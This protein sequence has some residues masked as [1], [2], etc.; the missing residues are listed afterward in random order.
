MS[1]TEPK[2][3]PVS[4]LTFYL[5]HLFESNPILNGVQ[6][7][8]EVSNLTYHRSGHVY[9]SLKDTDAQLSCVMFRS[10]AASAPKMEVGDKVIVKGSMT[11]YAP[12]GNYQ[13]M[14]RSVR[15]QGLGDLYQQFLALKDKLQ[16]EGLFESGRKRPLPFL[17][18]R[19][20]VLTSPTGAA[21]RDI[22]QT[23]Q[24]RWG[25]GEVIV[26]PTVVQGK[27]GKASL[28]KSLAALEELKADVAIVGRGGGSIEDL[29][30]FNEEAVVRAVAACE[31]PII[32]G[33]G[34]ETDITLVDFVADVRASTPTAAAEQAVP[35]KA[36]L[37]A[38]LDE[39]ERQI[40][41]SLQYFVDFKRQIVDDYQ[42]RLV[43]AMRQHLR[44]QHHQ[45]ELLEAKLKAQDI[46][47]LLRQG[48]S[49]TLK[50]GQVQQSAEGLEV[51]DTLETIFT[52][53]RVRSRIEETQDFDVPNETP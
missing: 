5:K 42:G 35:E 32:S 30:N 4:E 8:G 15:K 43:Q 28:L 19:I 45:V 44:Q 47:Q 26:I 52:N 49:L 50:N 13:L 39:Y 22:L 9:F 14:V 12:R 37:I 51:G 6:V 25:Q 17:P 24:R 29:W 7:S 36:A 53:G 10:F 18:K 46:T 40:Q 1:Q 41:G 31:T 27:Q 23:L 48:Y 11:I 16:R 33:I 34:H 3:Y 21:V 20:A 2:V 38:T